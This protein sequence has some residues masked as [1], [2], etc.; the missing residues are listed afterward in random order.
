VHEPH[1]G[2]LVR[3]QPGGDRF[4]LRG[5]EEYEVGSGDDTGQMDAGSRLSRPWELGTEPAQW[6]A[7][8]GVRYVRAG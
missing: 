3:R 5:G 2:G 6:V 7:D 1:G 4:Y 8:V